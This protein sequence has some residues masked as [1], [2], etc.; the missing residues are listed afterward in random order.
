[1]AKCLI[2]MCGPS[3][4]GKSTWAKKIM[5]DQQ[6]KHNKPV[7][8]ISRDEVRFSML[9]EGEPY[10]SKEDEV[11]A[12]WIRRIQTFL[13]SDED[14]YIIADATHLSERSRNKTLDALTLPDDINILPVSVYPG[15]Q[16][17]LERN[18][19]RS[20]RAF[21]PRSVIRRMCATYEAPTSDE[22][23]HYYSILMKVEGD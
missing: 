4:G 13:D 15:V 3:G 1:M 7:Y 2:L 14:C 23:Y 12:E 17:C 21:V 18:D 19:K 10:F 9:A 11:F 5:V 22:K 8:Y 20:G 6:E 16:K